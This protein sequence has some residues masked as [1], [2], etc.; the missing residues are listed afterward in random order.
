MSKY[1]AYKKH[2]ARKRLRVGVLVGVYAL[3]A[4]VFTVQ[5]FVSAASIK[6]GKIDCCLFDFSVVLKS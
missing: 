6:Q 5:Q 1:L 3:I 4:F 2:T